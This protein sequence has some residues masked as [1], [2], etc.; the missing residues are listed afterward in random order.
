MEAKELVVYSGEYVHVV[1]HSSF[2]NLDGYL[3]LGLSITLR[4]KTLVISEHQ[5]HAVHTG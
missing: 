2:S 3:P 1:C 5:G 4:K